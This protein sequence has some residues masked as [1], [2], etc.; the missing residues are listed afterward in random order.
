[1]KTTV[2]LFDFRSAFEQ[3]RPNQFSYEA[4][5]T[6]FDHFEQYEDETG[7]EVELDVIAICCDFSEDSW[8]DIADNYSIDLS[9]CEDDDEKAETVRE[10]LEDEG[11][12]VG[13]GANGCY[14]YRNL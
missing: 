1:M 5:E 12:F 10:Y 4:L 6:L 14:V 2:S 9:A 3:A 7:M 11:S 13:E 8:Q